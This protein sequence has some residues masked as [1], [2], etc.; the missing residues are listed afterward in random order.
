MLLFLVAGF[1]FLVPPRGVYASLVSVDS[2]GKVTWQ[3]LGYEIGVKSVTNDLASA[4]SLILL[5]RE[6]GKVVLNG[7]DVTSMNDNLVEISA[8][9]DTNDVKIAQADGVFDIEENGIKARTVFPL[10]VDPVKNELSVTTPSGERVI[11]I[12]PY[13][14]TLAL[15][16]ARIMD[17]VDDNQISLTE[18]GD[19]KLLYEVDGVRNINLFNI[20]K[21]DVKISSNISASNGEILKVDEPQWFRI[22]G[23]LFNSV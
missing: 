22:F 9:G 23:F 11:S 6:N 1:L 21:V 2:Q 12:L 15:I 3:I 17:K 14:A 18:S 13:E 20:A 5:K 19:G 4:G 8:R 10:T 16:R 7:V